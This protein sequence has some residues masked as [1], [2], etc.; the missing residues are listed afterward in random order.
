[1]KFVIA[2]LVYG[3]SAISLEQMNMTTAPCVCNCGTG[4]GKNGTACVA[5]CTENTTC[6]A[7]RNPW[8]HVWGLNE[9]NLMVE[10]RNSHWI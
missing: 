10:W 2:A 9:E 8:A 4:A 7:Q 1:M 5:G 3:V 6:L